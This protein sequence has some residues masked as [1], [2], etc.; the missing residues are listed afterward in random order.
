MNV[1]GK[2]RR[3]KQKKEFGDI[4]SRGWYEVGECKWKGCELWVLK[5]KM[6][7]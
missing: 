2:K 7:N 5:V 3:E 4:D 6:Q 1:E